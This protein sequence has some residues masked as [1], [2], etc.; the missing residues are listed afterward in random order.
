M[1]AY[2][3]VY[4][5][6]SRYLSTFLFSPI[7]RRGDG[8]RK[9]KSKAMYVSALATMVLLSGTAVAYGAVYKTLTVQDNGQ[10]KVLSGFGTG[11]LASFLQQH[12]IEVSTQD[13]VSPAL[14]TPVQNDMNVT[15][16]S[17]IAIHLQNGNQNK[18]VETF[19]HTVATLLRDEQITLGSGDSVSPELN[20]VLK[21]NET[22]SITKM[23]KRVTVQTQGIPFQ[24]IRQRTAELFQGE[25]HVLTYGVK[26][27][28]QVKTTSV[29]V[30]GHIVKKISTK[31]VLRQPI[32][33]VIEVGTTPNTYQL[34]SRSYSPGMISGQI[35][36]LATAY[37]QG[38]RTATGWI[39][40][41]GIVAVDPSVI[42]FGTRL[43][44]PGVGVVVAEDTGSDIVGRHID[45]CMANQQLADE[46][47]A[48]VVTVDVLN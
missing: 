23:S 12:G 30:N 14:S 11:T 22:V 17:P 15:I 8:V 48:Q 4:Y 6:Q 16:V 25:E 37:V 28:L 24:T 1:Y 27:L 45:I 32:N 35:T 47:G 33:E 46:W 26:G 42:P 7:V 9:P 29:Y 34:A 21:A 13:E 2:V 31:Q 36:V 20:S 10:R 19:A 40:R 5:A 44:I 3:S 38:G 43:Y 18:T 41:P 39:A